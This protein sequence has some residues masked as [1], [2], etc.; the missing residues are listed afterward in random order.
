MLAGPIRGMYHVGA[1]DLGS[2]LA[3]WELT[4]HEVFST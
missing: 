4:D 2:I 1:S 3:A